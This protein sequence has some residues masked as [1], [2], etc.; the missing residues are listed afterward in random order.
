MVCLGLCA[1]LELKHYRY[2]FYIACRPI[3]IAVTYNNYF[4][5]R[6]SEVLQ[7]ACLSVCLYEWVSSF[8]TAHQHITVTQCH[9]NVKRFIYRRETRATLCVGWNVV[10]YCTNNAN[11]SQAFSAIVT[12][13]TAT[14]TVLYTHRCNMLNYRTT[15]W[16]SVLQQCTCND[17]WRESYKP[18][19]TTTNVVDNTAY[20]SLTR[21]TLADG[22]KFSAVRRLCRRLLD[23]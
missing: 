7:S 3:K 21:T 18:T 15:S 16:C 5:P 12:F 9:G 1:V 8:L 6:G 2:F 19:S 4:A 13:S 20:P 23:L 17:R 22:Y 11:R 10:N 14:C